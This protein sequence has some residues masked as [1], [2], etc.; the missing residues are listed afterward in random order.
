MGSGRLEATAGPTEPVMP[1]SKLALPVDQSVSGSC[2]SR[3]TPSPAAGARH[4]L[5]MTV[6]TRPRIVASSPGMGWKRSLCGS[7]QVFP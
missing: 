4:S 3:A 5:R 7:S 2:E 1:L 6:T